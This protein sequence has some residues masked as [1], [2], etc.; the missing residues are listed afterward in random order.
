MEKKD[1]IIVAIVAIVAIVV[2]VIVVVVVDVRCHF[3]WSGGSRFLVHCLGMADLDG[4]VR[5]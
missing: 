4:P 3:G 1:I 5:F 2:V